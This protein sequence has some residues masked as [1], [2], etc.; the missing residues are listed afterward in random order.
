MLIDWTT[1][2]F[3]L[4]NFLLLVVLLKRFL[5][6]PI[7]RAM[8]RRE[9]DLAE[10]RSEALRLRS[11]AEA[12]LADYLHQQQELEEERAEL[13]RRTNE[14]AEARR[15]ELLAQARTE[16][17]AQRDQWRQA[18]RGQQREFLAE[19]Q[20]RSV[21][22]VLTLARRALAEL[23]D[24]TLE[25]A[26]ARV[27]LTRLQELPESDQARFLAMARGGRLVARGGFAA[28]KAVRQKLGQT[29]GDKL[30]ATV[31]L[32]WEENLDATLDIEIVGD[33]LRLAWGV[34]GYLEEVRQRVRKLFEEEERAG[35]PKSDALREEPWTE[36][37][38]A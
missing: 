16:A 38:K 7:T 36:P 6:G 5:Y 34:S 14:E 25:N 28:D 21:T 4:F 11:E 33:G 24:E 18:L 31:E 35:A 1:V 32:A 13:L 2:A 19:L 12:A 9:A 3:Q 17:E 10:I 22:G 37:R 23:T 30:G 26:L 29:L 8:D 20:Q 27:L 15:R